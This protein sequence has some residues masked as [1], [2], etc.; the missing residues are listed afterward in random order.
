[1]K[2]NTPQKQVPN[3]KLK[4]KKM[5]KYLAGGIG[6]V[7]IGGIVSV[8]Y[9]FLNLDH[10]QNK[11]NHLILIKTGYQI[12]YTHL[13]TGFDGIEPNI[14]ISN[15]SL[16]NP[17]TQQT[18]FKI[19]QI[20]LTLSYSSLIYLQPIF[21]DIG[22]YGS[23]L[24]FEYDQHDN[25][26]LNN[27]T[28]TNLSTP[29]RNTFDWE[30]LFLQQKNISIAN[31]NLSLLDS[32]HKIRPMIINKLYFHAQNLGANQHNL[33]L[34]VKF[35][36]SHLEAK[37]NFD[38]AR[39]SQIDGWDNGILRINSVGTKGYLLNLNAKVDDGELK[40]IETT[41]DSNQQQVNSYTKQIADISDFKGHL[42]IKQITPQGYI[43][44]APDLIIKTRYGYLFDHASINGGFTLGKGGYLNLKRLKLAGVNNLLKISDINDKLTLSGTIDAVNLAWKGKILKPY[45][46]NLTTSFSDLAVSSAESSIPSFNNLNGVI[47]AR[48]SSGEIKLTMNNG[49]LNYPKF[50]YQPYKIQHFNS[51]L[52][53]NIESKNK[54]TLAWQQTDL[55]MPEASLSSFGSYRQAESNLNATIGIHNIKLNQVYK[56]LPT[57]VN[58]DT[59]KDL[60]QNLVSG[61]LN[62][63]VIKIDGNP[64]NFPFKHESGS[65]TLN[66]DINNTNYNFIPKWTGVTNLNGKLSAKNQIL[67]FKVLSANLDH[68]QLQGTN[69]SVND[70]SQNHMTMTGEVHINGSHEDYLDYARQSP[71]QTQIETLENQLTEING[72]AKT[73]IKVS[74]PLSTPNR[75]KMNGS[76]T[77]E[78]SS[79]GLKSP[80][81][82]ISSIYGKLN[83]SQNGLEKSIINAEMLNSP[84]ELNI[85]NRNELSI[86]STNLDYESIATL[87]KPQLAQII[88]GNAPTNI[89][90]NLATQQLQFHSNLVGVQI[91]APEPLAKTE[92]STS[93]L[94]I[95]VNL[96][97]NNR[98]LQINYAQ[99]LAAYANLNDHFNLTKLYLGVGKNNLSPQATSLESAPININVFLE[100][101][102]VNEWANF[103]KK[104]R[105]PES[106][107]NE[108]QEL[109]SEQDLNPTE[110]QMESKE[111]ESHPEYT[112]V[113]EHSLWP[114]N[115]NLTTNAFWLSNYN[116]VGGKINLHI[117]PE[118]INA[119]ISTPDVEGKAEYLITDN[120]L[121]LDLQRVIF[122]SKNFY[123]KAE[124][125]PESLPQYSE[126]QILGALNLVSSE[127]NPLNESNLN[128]YPIL[129]GIDKILRAPDPVVKDDEDNEEFLPNLDES[130]IESLP[131]QNKPKEILNLPTTKIKIHNLYL[132]DYYWGSLSG[133]IYQQDDSLY[134]ENFVIRNQA[135]LT[136]FNLTNHCMSCSPKDG[137]Y[138]ALNLHSDIHNFGNLVIK[139]NQGD[140]FS[141]GNGTM[142]MSAEWPGGLADFQRDKVNARVNLNINDGTLVHVNPG[143]FGA[144]MGVINFSALN[145]SNINHFSL[146]SFF[147]KSLAYK[148]LNAN[149]HMEHDI[150]EIQN[151]DL[152]GDVAKIN[153]FG[154]Y[155]PESNT[156]D[157]YVTV[158]PRIGGTVATTAG[159]VTLNPIIG[160]FVYL[161]EKLIGDPINKALA[162]SYHVEG[163]IENPTMTQTKISNQL[164]QNF[165][166]S[167]DFL[168]PENK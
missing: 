28:V 150:V 11:I 60:Q 36:N 51:A 12:N 101:T 85:I 117:D 97:T 162:I 59:I 146:N 17:K 125:V 111:T 124:S 120:K 75:L 153:S 136:N 73:N 106:K 2:K 77:I 34:N 159:I 156:V 155:Y 84:L 115:M 42:S 53:W 64:S 50:L 94:D 132:E 167:L 110:F 19:K 164:M 20:N 88:H 91:N 69:L 148:N 157:T 134:L 158:E 103:F 145:I 41:L 166:S 16:S 23:T 93:N 3:K 74:V 5:L 48:E 49:M 129:A 152:L 113:I 13:N 30:Q 80:E 81:T 70:I 71:Y 66:G 35:P 10:Y 133:N 96:A 26:R 139:L 25:L 7:A 89:T 63:T 21:S 143:L 123:I 99:Q 86:S 90:Y 105:M 127:S 6:I 128:T 29:T 1:M 95:G 87:L 161:G 37:L 22:L 108:S 39:L 46:F 107:E 76:Y 27:E 165:K 118:S 65:F 52:N 130:D 38:G 58:K 18:F 56:I 24:N 149:V 116:M 62:K 112:P 151:L 131:V 9:L 68:L 114:I 14:K 33:T 104:L 163:P 135:L 43:I 61:S 32:K 55:Q 82:K 78:S 44:S 79:V 137:G 45:D 122:S 15:L 83:F 67:N 168:Q 92:S 72:F 31:I 138:V 4:P 47:N 57:T 142:D 8:G 154:N 147:G 126:S 119:Q 102:L 100:Q 160:I 109:L 40:S 121:N 144:L 98:Q 54:I 140:M 141:N